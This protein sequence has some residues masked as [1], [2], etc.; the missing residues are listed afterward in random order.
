[1]MESREIGVDGPEPSRFTDEDAQRE[2]E[3]ESED[4]ARPRTPVRPNLQASTDPKDAVASGPAANEESKGVARDARQIGD[5]DCR[6]DV[7]QESETNGHTVTP[8]RPPNVPAPSDSEGK[9]PVNA[10]A[11]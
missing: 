1:M 4:N 9:E 3:I 10:G 8:V 7:E 2:V 5:E 11:A 6:Q